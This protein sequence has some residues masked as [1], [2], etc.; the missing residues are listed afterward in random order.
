VDF[1]AYF[2][3]KNERIRHHELA[4]FLKVDGDWFFDDGLGVP[5]PQVVR[6]EPKIGRNDPCPCN[7]G[8]KFKKCCGK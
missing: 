5:A 4:T 1:I 6:T 8:K 3:I 2:K 7:S